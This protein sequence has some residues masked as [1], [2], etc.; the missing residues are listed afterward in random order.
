MR[1]NARRAPVRPGRRVPVAQDVG[2]AVQREEVVAV[3]DGEGAQPQAS[4]V[5]RGG[6][7]GH[8]AMLPA[9]GGCGPPN[10]RGRAAPDRQAGSR[11][12]TRPT[13]S[14][15]SVAP[16]YRNS[17][18]FAGGEVAVGLAVEVDADPAV[19]VHRGV[20]EAVPGVR[21]PE[22]AVA[23]S[24]SAGSPSASRHA[25]CHRVR[26]LA[27]LRR[28]SRR[29]GAARPP[30][31][32]DRA[33]ELLPRPGVRRSERERPLGH[34]ELLREPP[35]RRAAARDGW[36][37]CRRR[38]ARPARPARSSRTTRSRSETRCSTV[39]RPGAPA[40]TRKT[41]VPEPPAPS[42]TLTRKA[43][44]AAPAPQHCR[45]RAGRRPWWGSGA[46]A[47]RTSSSA[48]AA[49]STRSPVAR[50]GQ[51]AVA[52]LP[53]AELGDRQRAPGRAPP[54]GTGA[55]VLPTSTSTRHSSMRPEPAAAERPRGVASDAAPASSAHSPRSKR[56][57]A[58]I[59][60]AA[61]RG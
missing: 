6:G 57:P 27:E 52:L 19:H 8:A 61:G 25:A 46:R 12:G 3:R 15:C 30:G 4:G 10:S 28:C 45:R 21:G 50:A 18:C 59:D 1:G 7:Q 48:M 54:A 38:P 2:V 42:A 9:R 37:R 33:A 11:P 29:P 23:T 31:S 16:P 17:K 39:V 60:S 44:A 32:A 56:S 5:Q 22:V 24:T 26:S 40:S 47:G 43:S 36:R 13:R 35:P 20:R 51:P 58:T 41:P 55:T 53:G 34:A 49:V 14:A